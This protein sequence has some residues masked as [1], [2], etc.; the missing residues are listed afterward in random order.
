MVA[1]TLTSSSEP[2]LFRAAKQLSD[3][4]LT[5]VKSEKYSGLPFIVFGPF[6]AQVYKM[7]EKYRMKMM[8]KCRN[9]KGARALFRE[10]LSEFSLM[11]GVTLAVD[12]NPQ[13]T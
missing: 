2:E 7:N 11:R 6:E 8:I 5:K 4:L 1:L 12:I 3:T 9:S 13:T 10:L